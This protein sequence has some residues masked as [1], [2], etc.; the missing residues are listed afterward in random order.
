M[1]PEAITAL[2]AGVTGL[3]TALATAAVMI[4]KQRQGEGAQQSEIEDKRTDKQIRDD[5]K[6]KREA[7]K[8]LWDLYTEVKLELRNARN[9][10][11]QCEKRLIRLEVALQA[12]NM[13]LPPLE[14][15][16]E[17]SDDVT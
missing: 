10:E 6:A 15:D 13:P 1:S 14:E 5:A 2:V 9:R 7:S 16:T 12:N 4:L 17:D 3:V 11:R 8:E